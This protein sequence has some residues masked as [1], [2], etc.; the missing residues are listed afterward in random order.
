[1]NNNIGAVR[2]CKEVSSWSPIVSVVLVSRSKVSGFSHFPV[3][4]NTLTCSRIV[5]L[6]F[7]SGFLTVSKFGLVYSNSKEEQIPLYPNK[8]EVRSLRMLQNN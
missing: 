6:E 8:E 3:S 4:F 2:C 5:H 7:L 1:M